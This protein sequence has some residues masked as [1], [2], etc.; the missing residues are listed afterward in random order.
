MAIDTT[1]PTIRPPK[2]GDMLDDDFAAGAAPRPTYATPN[3]AFGGEGFASGTRGHGGNVPPANRG[4]R[5]PPG[6]IDINSGVDI[7]GNPL[8]APDPNRM[9]QVRFEG[10]AGAT[11]GGQPPTYR[12][13]TGA[14]RAEDSSAAVQDF[15]TEGLTTPSRYDSSL[16][17]DITGQIDADLTN[18]RQFATNEMDEF[19][20]QRGMVGSNVEGELRRGL[21]GDLERQR[22][23]RLNEL[24]IQAANT[25]AQDRT[26]AAD[27][28]F[29]SG[30]FERSLGGDRVNDARFSAEFGQSQFESDR[31]YQTNSRIQERALDLQEKGMDLENAREQAKIQ[32]QQ[33]QFKSESEQQK[34]MFDA[35][36]TETRQQRLQDLG[37]TQQDFDLRVQQVQQSAIESGRTLDLAEAQFE[38]DRDLRVDQL[39]QEAR[40]ADRSFNMDD[41]RLRAEQEQYQQDHEFRQ[42]DMAQRIDMDHKQYREQVE[43]RKAEYGDRN[44]E[45]LGNMALQN[46]AQG[47]DREMNAMNRILEERALTLQE[48]G[49]A[50][51]DAWREADRALTEELQTKALELQETS[52]TDDEAYRYA[53]LNANKE[54]SAAER[55]LQSDLQTMEIDSREK[56]TLAEQTLQADLQALQLEFAGEELAEQTKAREAQFTQLNNEL[57]ERT[58]ARKAQFKELKDQ[59]ESTEDIQE[60]A[61]EIAQDG[62][63]KETSWRTAANTL[64]KD[65]QA[66]NRKLAREDMDVKKWATEEDLQMR[67]R[68]FAIASDADRLKM[69]LD[70]LTSG[71]NNIDAGAIEDWLAKHD[72]KT[73]S[74]PGSNENPT[75]TGFDGAQKKKVKL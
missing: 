37:V 58:T 7:Y 41:A 34:E 26:A 10:G 45:R 17:Q 12:T 66:E 19:M 11:A 51:E 18:K 42:Q 15:A 56:I 29:R 13:P 44:A 33:E 21:Y 6:S 38:A 39:E 14:F 22:S 64:E 3:V 27:T 5:L 36:M 63:D 71:S 23:E 20:S 25:Y 73:P 8:E 72:E 43:T 52:L 49:M 46:D 55:T 74:G 35:S 32:I 53:E 40:N 1:T 30:E 48:D 59:R 57:G 16:I 2:A 4:P 24:N 65:I 61:N 69:T 67:E 62:I 31:E 47:Y 54:I 75:Y 9:E 68:E 60:R 50:N 70:A 28:A